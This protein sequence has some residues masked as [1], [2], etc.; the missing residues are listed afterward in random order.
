MGNQARLVDDVTG[1]LSRGTRY[2]NGFALIAFD[3]DGPTAGEDEVRAVAHVVQ[4]QARG[5]DRCY[6]L[7][8]RVVSLL[9][10]QGVGGASLAAE[11]IRAAV[12][13]SGVG[14]VSAGVGAYVP[15]EDEFAEDVIGRAGLMARQSALDGGD[16]VTVAETNHQHGLTDLGR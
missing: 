2:G 16:R 11:R 7:G 8:A 3:V 9:P 4:E 12:A 6:R 15:W 5:A 13:E 1:L 10:E 14:T